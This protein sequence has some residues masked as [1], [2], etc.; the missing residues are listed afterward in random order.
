MAGHGIVVLGSINVDLTATVGC[1][2]GRGETVMGGALAVAH[3]GKGANQGVAAARAGAAVEMVGCVGDDAEGTG[4]LGALEAEGVGTRWVRVTRGVRT[5]TA[6]I[7]VEE[8]SGENMI[9]VC[10]GANAE[11]S[12]QQVEEARET[13]QGAAL[14]MAQLEVPLEAVQRAAEL[15]HE[16]GGRFVLNPSPVPPDGVPQAL[17]SNVTHLVCNETEIARIGAGVGASDE[18]TACRSLL[19]QGMEAVVVTRGG[20]GCSLHNIH[21]T[22]HV[23]PFVVQ[24]VDAVGAGDAFAG[25]LCAALC[26]GA[27]LV[28]A[29][30]FANAAGALATTVAGA[31]PSLP[32]RMAIEALLGG[33]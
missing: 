33:G 13:L 27:P 25:A 8:G 18:G 1:L 12:A 3:G 17:L 20:R 4:Y 6:L 14:V 15:V 2:P 19:E 31:M 24:P 7:L 32:R 11:V 30:A 10:P 9:A 16:A 5:G 29:A 28:E 23:A 21:G 22:A 26:D